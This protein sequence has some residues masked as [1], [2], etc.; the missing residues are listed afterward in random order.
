VV[1]GPTTTIRV[2]PAT[3]AL[4]TELSHAANATM[5]DTVRDAARAL[6]QYR[7][8]RQVA[9]EM[10]ELMRDPEVWADYLAEGEVTH[11]SDGIA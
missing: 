7:F 1:V 3:H 2:D 8:A 5:V 10:V 6:H 9:G 4:L 11:V